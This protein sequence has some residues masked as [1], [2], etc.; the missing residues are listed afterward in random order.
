MSFYDEENPFL[1]RPRPFWEE[2]PVVAPVVPVAP[3]A[4][5]LPEVEGPGYASPEDI[6]SAAPP[7]VEGPGYANANEI[8]VE[9]AVP[10][11]EGPGYASLEEVPGAEPEEEE[12]FLSKA[13]KLGQVAAKLTLPGLGQAAAVFDPD[14]QEKAIEIADKTKNSLRSGWLSGDVAMELQ[15]PEPSLD[16]VAQQQRLIDTLKPDQDFQTAWDDKVT[17]EASWN[18]FKKDPVGNVAQLFGQSIGAMIRSGKDYLYKIPERAWQGT[19]GGAAIGAP[20]AGVGAVPG[21]ALGL[22]TGVTLG[23]AEMNSL[24]SYA[25]EYAGSVISSLGEAGIDV[26]DAA[27]LKA[28]FSNPELMA[29]IRAKAEKKGVPVAFFDGLSGAVNGNLFAQPGKTLGKKAW[30]WGAELLTDSLLGGTGEAASQVASEGGIT[31]WRSILAEIGMEPI[32]SVPQVAVGR[33]MSAI[34]QLSEAPG[35]PPA[36]PGAVLP[37]G[38]EPPPIPPTPDEA[39]AP[40]VTITPAP[41]EV[42]TPADIAGVSVTGDERFAPPAP[43]APGIFATDPEARADISEYLIDK[44]DRGLSLASN[45]QPDGSI[46]VSYG[47]EV[48]NQLTI[49]LTPEE[50]K[51]LQMASNDLELAMQTGAAEEV[52]AARKAQQDILQPATRKRLSEAISP[53]TAAKTVVYKVQSDNAKVEQVASEQAQNLQASAAPK[54]AEAIQQVAQAS[55]TKVSVTAAEFLQQAKAAAAA[56]PAPPVTPAV[57]EFQQQF[58]QAAA[59]PAQQP[60]QAAPVAAEVPAVVVGGQQ[61]T[62]ATPAEAFQAAHQAVGAD[63]INTAVTGWV[64]PESGKFVTHEVFDAYQD[65]KAAID[66]SGGNMEAPAVA[67]AGARMAQAQA[68]DEQVNSQIVQPGGETVVTPGIKGQQAVIAVRPSQEL[69][70]P[71]AGVTVTVEGVTPDG[72]QATEQQPAAQALV[73]A[74]NDKTAFTILLDCLI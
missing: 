71:L 38:A 14:T 25:N 10:E 43:P 72:Q 33:T 28:A 23:M 48:G 42:P 21:A 35:A 30:Q 4:A 11:V 20:L 18:A 63:A 32:A 53:D 62:G 26:K 12:S 55:N 8:P 16:Y 9:E 37:A 54:T 45:V 67:E 50:R 49:N 15:K 68:R 7:E 52:A 1:S 31:S 13:A 59:Q 44:M 39:F 61:F 6:V 41:G 22:R 65:L 24:A 36:V 40:G 47:T 56:P 74:R 5:T 46:K 2:E 29:G 60:A 27:Q 17:P 69:V 34:E 19:A 58:Q 51:G 66:Q 70:Q 64:D 3:P 57:P 73:D